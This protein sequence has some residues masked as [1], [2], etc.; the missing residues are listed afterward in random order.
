M[1]RIF[2]YPGTGGDGDEFV[3]PCCA[4]LDFIA[5]VVDI[6]RSMRA[7]P[8]KISASSSSLSSS[9]SGLLTSTFTR[10]QS[11]GRPLN[12]SAARPEPTNRPSADRSDAGTTT[13]VLAHSQN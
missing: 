11:S 13:A 8:E 2:F 1:G 12:V 6:E 7:E 4:L 10:P 3:F 5:G 9:L